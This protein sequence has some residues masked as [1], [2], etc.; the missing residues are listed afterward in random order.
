[1]KLKLWLTEHLQAT[2][3]RDVRAHLLPGDIYTSLSATLSL[4]LSAQLSPLPPSSFST[5]PI[6][7]VTLPSSSPFYPIASDLN[8]LPSSPFLPTMRYYLSS[9]FSPLLLLIPGPLLLFS[10]PSPL[11]S[12]PSF[13]PCFSAVKQ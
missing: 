10:S 13:H 5:R 1:M 2:V 4:C 12:S 3:M 7:T 8:S 9:H 11:L 6:R